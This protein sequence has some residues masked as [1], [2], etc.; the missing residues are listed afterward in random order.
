MNRAL[1]VVPTYDEI[2][3]LGR[4]AEQLLA[5]PLDLELLIVDDASPDGTGRLADRLAAGEP[6]IHT[7]HRPRKSGIGPAYVDGFRWALDSGAP[8]IVQMDADLSHDPRDLP[9]LLATLGRCD[10]ALG[11]RYRDGIRVVGWSLKRLLLSLTASRYARAVLRM[12]VEDPTSGF[13]AFRREALAAIPWGRIRSRGYVFQVETTYWLWRNGYRVEEIPIIFH[14]RR[15]GG[16]KISRQIV[17]E[18]LL[19]IWQM[20]RHRRRADGARESPARGARRLSHR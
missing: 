9:R 16:S 15:R 2:D 13:K 14:D 11:S 6:R 20:G 8:R 1:V 10:V 5:L 19:V 12:P 7:L 18:A 4:L 3:N 17:W